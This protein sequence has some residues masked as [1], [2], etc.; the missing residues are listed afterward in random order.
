MPGAKSAEHWYNIEAVDVMADNNAAAVVTLGDSITDGRGSTS[1]GNNRWPD[2]LAARLHTNAPT[3]QVSVL[4]M[5]I[6]GNTILFG[7]LGPTAEKRFDRDVIDRSGVR[8]LIIFE[9]VNDIGGAGGRA[10]P[11]WRQISSPPSSSLPARRTRK[12]SAFMV[13][14]SRRLAAA[15]IIPLNTRRSARKS[16]RGSARIQF[17][18]VS[19]ILTPPCA[20]RTSRS[21]SRRN[22]IPAFTQMIGC[23]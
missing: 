9:G 1:D 17:S 15:A 2:D 21:N 16:M 12:T 18:T 14:P 8:W 7:G 20:I 22:I 6:G 4:N 23:T 3:A 10:L 5:G 13:R 11:R 19:L